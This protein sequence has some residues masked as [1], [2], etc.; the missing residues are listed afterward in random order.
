MRVAKQF[1]YVLILVATLFIASCASKEF[2]QAPAPVS[3]SY[4]N[5]FKSASPRTQTLISDAL[6]LSKRRLRYQYGSADPNNGGMD[7]S[8]TIYYLLKGYQQKQIPRQSDQMYRW[9]KKKGKFYP[10]KSRRF[11]AK[12]FSH[13]KPGDLLFWTGTYPVKR[14]HQITHVMLYLGKSKQGNRLMFGA[15]NGRTYKYKR[16]HGVSVFDFY[17]PSLK[18]KSRFIGY[19][20]IPNVNCASKNTKRM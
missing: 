6:N 3:V 11:N 19:G 9:V 5:E 16:N 18:S 14:K 17:L 15:S 8:G 13:L 10:V 2:T 4:L 12:E 1:I 20:C 7:C